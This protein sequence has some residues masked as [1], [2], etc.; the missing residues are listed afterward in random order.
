MAPIA[1]LHITSVISCH[2]VGGQGSI[3]LVRGGALILDCQLCRLLPGKVSHSE[4]Q[5][6]EGEAM[7]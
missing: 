6:G 2:C 1:H 5:D 3:N 7:K 4:I